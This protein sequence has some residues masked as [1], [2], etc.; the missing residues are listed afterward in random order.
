MREVAFKQVD[1]FPQVAFGGNPVAVI[2]DGSG[3]DGC[4]MQAIARWT[5]LSET[6]FVLPATTPAASYR[7]RIFTPRR[8]LPFAGHPSVGTAHAVLE[9]GLAEAVDGALVQECAAGLL[10]VRV[11]E[12]AP[13][14]RIL[15]RAPAARLAPLPE[16]DAG[17]LLAA[18]GA[19]AGA[20]VTARPAAVDVGPVW[21]V[22]QLGDAAR[23]RALEPDL[24]ALAALSDATGAVGI[25]VFGAEPDDAP[26]R[27]AVRSFCP[28]DG[29]D[30]D[31]VC[32]S[33]NA[34]VGA[35]LHAAGAAGDGAW[36][37]SQGR[38]C[39]RDG[40]VAVRIDADDRVWI[41]GGATTRIEGRIA[42]G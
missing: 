14:R 7:V 29:I 36:T 25:T 3:L 38:E 16:P 39:G 21:L 15:V 42:L 35:W 28:A 19:D 37:S 30:E 40:R 8:E 23:V 41:G 4:A 32:G 5:N 2:L 11:E 13:Q 27:Y 10:P 12:D 26:D 31:P 20:A 1:V 33:G 18:L 22:L 9:A 6:T 34:A 17:L 24:A